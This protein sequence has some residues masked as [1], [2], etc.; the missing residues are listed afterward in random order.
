MI[1]SAGAEIICSKE[2]IATRK[3]QV[4][5]LGKKDFKEVYKIQKELVGR[6]YREE[7]PDTLIL[8]EHYPV[9][10][11]GR[12]GSRENIL[13][14]EEKL[15]E[16]GIQVYEIDRGGDITYHGPGQIVGYPVMDL[17]KQGRDVH[18]YL[19]KLEEVIIRF[20]ATY[21]I[22]GERIEGMTGVWIQNKKIASIGIGISKW[23]TYHGFCVNLYPNLK[24]FQM[25]N[26]CGLGKPVTSLREI[27]DGTPFRH[28]DRAKGVSRS[29]GKLAST[30]PLRDKL[31]SC[32]G[33]VFNLV[34]LREGTDC[35]EE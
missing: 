35:A 22:Q 24:H 3:I 25:I 30:E 21:S 23:I 19:R 34:L 8:T 32:F 10:T 2:M 15:E 11:I 20:L 16:E 31:V 12:S 13:C 7:I 26:P 5:D 17:R 28:S 14:S 18:L 1:I 9:F 33:E 27:L 29:R 6:R 4:L